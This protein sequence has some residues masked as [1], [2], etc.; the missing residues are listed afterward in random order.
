MVLTCAYTI[1]KYVEVVRRLGLRET[2]VFSKD[3]GARGA[4]NKPTPILRHDD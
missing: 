3:L 4:K 1:E 2:T